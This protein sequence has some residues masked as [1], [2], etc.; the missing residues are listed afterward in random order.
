[1]QPYMDQK[2]VDMLKKILTEY[3]FWVNNNQ[4][5]S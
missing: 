4:K 2:L 5:L 3:F 1:M